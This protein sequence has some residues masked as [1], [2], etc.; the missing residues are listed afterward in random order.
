VFAAAAIRQL[1]K[2][3]L[4]YKVDANKSVPANPPGHLV[5]IAKRQSG[6]P[7]WFPTDELAEKWVT[8]WEEV[9]P[10]LQGDIL[11]WTVQSKSK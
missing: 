3:G 4:I 1:A 2:L 6:S 8:I 7:I 5:A 9:A 10:S 11:H